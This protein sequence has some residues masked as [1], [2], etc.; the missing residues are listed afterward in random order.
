MFM[1]YLLI[2]L[3]T[4]PDS[5]TQKTGKIIG[6][7]INEDSTGASKS[8]IFLQGYNIRQYYY[9]CDSAG[10]FEICVPPGT[11]TLKNFGAIK[12]SVEVKADSVSDLGTMGAYFYV[13]SHDEIAGKPALKANAAELKGT[14]VTPHLEQK[15]EKGKN[16]LWCGTLQLVWNELCDNNGGPIEAKSHS[17]IVDILNKRLISKDDLDEGDYVAMAGGGPGFIDK[18]F[19]EL[20]RKFGGQACPTLLRSY[21]GSDLIAYAYLFKHLPFKYVFERRYHKLDFQGKLVDCFAFPFSH[22][23]ANASE[24]AEQVSI[25]DYKNNDDFI[26]ELKTTVK[27]NQLILAKISPKKTLLETV[28]NVEKRI[29]GANPSKLTEDEAMKVPVLDFDILREYNEL[30]ET[31]AGP[32]LQSIRFRLD[33]AGAV[34]KSEVVCLGLSTGPERSFIFD[35]PFLILIKRKEARNPYFALWV[36]NSDLLVSTEKD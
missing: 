26:L 13:M 15:I 10:Y 25:L 2:L 24:V 9:G 8:T 11:Y 6:R 33:E 28:K 7:I 22:H 34:L 32:V 23:I 36:G 19:K 5:S 3:S 12:V 30:Y 1:I 29:K 31:I 18:I 16:I 35:K 17:S 20:E 4:T 27:D 21:E 14:I